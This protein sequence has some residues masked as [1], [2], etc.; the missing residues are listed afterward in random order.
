MALC[1]LT[2]SRN[3]AQKSIRELGLY[4]M[5][6]YQFVVSEGRF[7]QH[8]YSTKAQVGTQSTV[9]NGAVVMKIQKHRAQ[10]RFRVMVKRK[11]FK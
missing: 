1:K 9:G 2:D 6:S 11:G 4:L 10:G 8:G 7:G 5:Q 3:K